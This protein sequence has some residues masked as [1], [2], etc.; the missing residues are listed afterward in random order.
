MLGLKCAAVGIPNVGR[1]ENSVGCFKDGPAKVEQSNGEHAGPEFIAEDVRR[2]EDRHLIVVGVG[3]DGRK[4]DGRRSCKWARYRVPDFERV[5]RGLIEG[6]GAVEQGLRWAKRKL[7][8]NRAVEGPGLAFED[9]AK[10]RL[11]SE[12]NERQEK[13]FWISS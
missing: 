3:D 11:G 10:E 7:H 9:I 8:H 2:K 12:H 6:G 5:L 4:E 13:C 1:I